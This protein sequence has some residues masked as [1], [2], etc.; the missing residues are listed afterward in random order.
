MH[1]ASRD[2][3]LQACIRGGADA[4]ASAWPRVTPR[5]NHGVVQDYAGMCGCGRLEVRLETG[6]APDQFRPRSDAATC[7]FCREH[8]G[9]WISDPR[10]A[11]V[12][13]AGGRTRVTRFASEQVE[14]HF[15]LDCQ[16]LAYAVFTDTALDRVVAVVR[17]GLFEAIR[18]AAQP[19]L[20]T[21]FEGQTLEG[22]RQRRLDTWTPVRR[23]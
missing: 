10:G 12:L 17:V 20:V 14:F 9:V 8:D 13:P 7:G 16:E 15:C 21:C 22:G 6:V 4:G 3:H 5:W 1:A 11:L 19:T 2:V 18:A 23:P